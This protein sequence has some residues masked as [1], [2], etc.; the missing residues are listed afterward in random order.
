MKRR[1]NCLTFNLVVG[2]CCCFSEGTLTL[3]DDEE[4][5]AFGPVARET[6]IKNLRAYPLVAAFYLILKD[7]SSCQK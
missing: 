5:G 7:V 6:K 2:C 4:A 3:V 1:L